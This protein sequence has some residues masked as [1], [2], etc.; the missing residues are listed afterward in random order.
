MDLGRRPAEA[1]SLLDALRVVVPDVEGYTV[2]PVGGYLVTRLR[3]APVNGETPAFDLA[4]ESEG[5][6]RVLGILA[7]LHQTPRIPLVA[8]EEPELNIH[9]GAIGILRDVL[10]EAARGAQV[11]VTTHKP[12]PD[13]RPAGGH[14]DGRGEGQRRHE[15]WADQR[16][17]APGRHREPLLARRADADGRPAKRG[18]EVSC[19]VPIVEGQGDMMA[20]PVLLRRI[21]WHHEWWHWTVGQPKRA[22]G[23]GALRKRLEH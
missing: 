4:H 8:V 17:P 13:R 3:H 10:L 7:A 11:I 19:I 16:G 22:G 18:A 2:E 9:P 6:L 5:T 12:G 23:L 20:V 14:A 1:A 15:G 21:L